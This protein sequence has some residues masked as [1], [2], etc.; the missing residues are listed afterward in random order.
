[1]TAQLGP[2]DLTY[3]TFGLSDENMREASR[4]PEK[5]NFG[6]FQ[7]AVQGHS[8]LSGQNYYDFLR[9][10]NGLRM[11]SLNVFVTVFACFFVII[12]VFC[13]FQI[14]GFLRSN[15]SKCLKSPWS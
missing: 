3:E 2:K 5:T 6:Q 12:I 15:S 1:M 10:S 4:P 9:L 11:C 13:C 8:L 7:N 14:H